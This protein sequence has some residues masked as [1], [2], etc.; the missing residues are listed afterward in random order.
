MRTE[1]TNFHDAS[2]LARSRTRWTEYPIPHIIR[3]D[4]VDLTDDRASVARV[5]DGK[6]NATQVRHGVIVWDMQDA[7]PGGVIIGGRLRSSPSALEGPGGGQTVWRP[8]KLP[9]WKKAN[10]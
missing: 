9:I 1:Q 2:S 3:F 10:P 7:Q 5:D 6:V 4:H 8:R